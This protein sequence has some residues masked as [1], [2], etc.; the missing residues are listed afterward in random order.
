MQQIQTFL[1]SVQKVCI[2]TPGIE[3]FT[4]PEQAQS[5]I[6]FLNA[7]PD[8]K[9]LGEVGF[10]VGVSSAFMLGVRPDTLVYSFD[11]FE[12]SYSLAQKRMIDSIFPGRHLVITGDSTQT[13][14]LLSKI[15]KPIF[16][17]VFIDGGH[18]HPVPYLDIQNFL[19]LLK[20][21]GYMCV[22]DY[23]ESWGMKGVISA[24]NTFVKEGKL[25]H[26]SQHSFADRGWVFAQKPK[27]SEE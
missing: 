3:G 6:E 4:L 13:I 5:I 18:E 2:E 22:D 14:P 17:F 20:P 24:Y 27:P 9:I 16:D 11:L 19:D 21:G 25:I 8:C 23:C 15:S 12:K 26:M 1:E 7:H 10:N